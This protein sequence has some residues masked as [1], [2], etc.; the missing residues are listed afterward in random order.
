APRSGAHGAVT[1][2][3]GQP[4]PLAASARVRWAASGHLAVAAIRR[5][6]RRGEPA[7]PLRGDEPAVVAQADRRVG[8]L[9]RARHVLAP[10]DRSPRDSY[11]AGVGP[12]GLIPLPG[13]CPPVFCPV[14]GGPV[15]PP[16]RL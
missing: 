16:L 6:P 8:V 11:R 15:P 13:R 9:P 5:R 7:R 3:S 1:P 2:E 12:A 14:R 10:V 4:I